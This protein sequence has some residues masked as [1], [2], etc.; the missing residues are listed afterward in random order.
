MND[1]IGSRAVAILHA[2]AWAHSIMPPNMAIPRRAGPSEGGSE[3]CTSE[4][5]KYQIEIFIGCGWICTQNGEGSTE[6]TEGSE[7]LIG[8]WRLVGL[9]CLVKYNKWMWVWSSMYE[10]VMPSPFL[11]SG[12]PLVTA[13]PIGRHSIM[14]VHQRRTKCP[15]SSHNH[16][17]ESNSTILSVHKAPRLELCPWISV[18]PKLGLPQRLPATAEFYQNSMRMPRQ[19][20]S[21]SI[22]EIELL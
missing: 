18:V 8:S 4:D 13:L 11:D 5:W 22:T 1:F 17:Q 3:T 6:L 16:A 21:W 12:L 7:R 14:R 10:T 20:Q 2:L 19:P 9:W 15:R